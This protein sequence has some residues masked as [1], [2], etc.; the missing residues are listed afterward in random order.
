MQSSPKIKIIHAQGNVSYYFRFP[1]GGTRRR[2]QFLGNS[3][4]SPTETVLKKCRRRTPIA[5][6][7]F[8]SPCRDRG[9]EIRRLDSTRICDRLVTIRE[10]STRR[11]FKVSLST[12]LIALARALVSDRGGG[13]G[14]N[15]CIRVCTWCTHVRKGGRAAWSSPPER[16]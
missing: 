14:T 10:R 5:G 11:R 1:V 6:H 13:G 15:V 3:D 4:I 8:T 9:C 16:K 7:F 2:D 12:A